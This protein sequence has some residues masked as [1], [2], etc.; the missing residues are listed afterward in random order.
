MRICIKNTKLIQS[1]LQEYEAEGTYRIPRLGNY[2]PALGLLILGNHCAFPQFPA[3]HLVDHCA[4]PQCPALQAQ[5]QRWCPA[6]GRLSNSLGKGCPAIH[7]CLHFFCS[8]GP[9]PCST[10]L[11]V[12]TENVEGGTREGGLL[13]GRS[14]GLCVEWTLAKTDVQDETC[15]HPLG[16]TAPAALSFPFLDTVHSTPTLSGSSPQNGRLLSLPCSTL[17]R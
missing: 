5:V 15:G 9:A 13:L 14:C 12:F 1:C 17:E 11:S 3:P 16:R 8:P 6:L 2:L 4:F 10:W 7:H